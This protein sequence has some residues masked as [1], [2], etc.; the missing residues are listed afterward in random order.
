MGYVKRREPKHYCPKPPVNQGMKGDL[1]R[2]DDCQQL[3]V[4]K[5]VLLGGVMW[6]EAGWRLRLKYRSQKGTLR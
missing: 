6:W 4:L 1:W 3:Y 2:C 5:D